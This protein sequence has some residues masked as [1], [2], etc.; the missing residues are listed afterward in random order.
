MEK[1]YIKHDYLKRKEVLEWIVHYLC[2]NMPALDEFP[3]LSDMQDSLEEFR[4]AN[5]SVAAF[6]S[7]LESEFTWNFFQMPFYMILQGLV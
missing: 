6:W 7:E 3:P 4:N 1:K 5:N 2:Y